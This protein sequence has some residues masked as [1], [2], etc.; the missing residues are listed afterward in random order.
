MSEKEK[1]Q[2]TLVSEQIPQKD[3]QHWILVGLV[4]IGCMICVSSILVGQTLVSGMSFY[5]ALAAGAIGYIVVLVVTIFQGTMASDLGR[6]TV[7]IAKP[8]F[9]EGAANII[10]SLI[11][12][13]A[14]I[15]WFGVQSTIAGASFQ[16]LV[17]LFN[18]NISFTVSTVLISLLMVVSAMYGFK[19]MEKLNLVAVPL[20]VIVLLYST[21]VA[22]SS[23]DLSS[24][25]S[26]VPSGGNLSL[27]NGVSIVF[28]SFVVG[29][30]I[31]GDFTRYNKNR[32]DTFK[33]AAFGIVPA[34]FLLLA[35]GAFLAVTA[36]EENADIIA[37]MTS[38]LPYP[39]IG[40]IT[41]I[42][43]TWTTNVSNAY[44]AGISL[45][46]AFK[47]DSSKRPLVTLVAG[48]V[49]TILAAVGIL[50][51]FI[52]FLLVLTAFVA[53]VAGVM[54]ADYWILNK[55]NPK[56]YMDKISDGRKGIVA[57]LLGTAPGLFVLFVPTVFNNF[58]NS[59]LGVIGIFVSM[60]VYLVLMGG[61]KNE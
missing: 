31:A 24:I 37:I 12:S 49:G 28:G 42:L 35:I 56:G 58:V 13:I 36:G 15:G 7:V 16:Q 61:N 14:L 41:L 17:A 30:A 48:G 32:K 10:F 8:S 26:Y 47:L 38:K 5:K 33:S 34:G 46:N 29:A 18:I 19:A 20:L 1:F 55:G 50:E 22:I 60:I 21:I 23:S 3:R 27:I 54:I 2:D 11:V 45:V 51:H 59:V 25:S 6:P 43:A 53:P 44:S 9:G 39:I 4:W 52:T 57:W 40:I